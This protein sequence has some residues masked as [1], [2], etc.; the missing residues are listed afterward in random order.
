MSIQ[1]TLYGAITSQPDALEHFSCSQSSSVLSRGLLIKKMSF[2]LKSKLP[3]KF[4]VNSRSEKNGSNG[5]SP[6]RTRI[7]YQWTIWSSLL[8]FNKFAEKPLLLFSVLHTTEE[9]RFKFSTPIKVR[10]V[11]IFP[12]H[13]FIV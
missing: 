1:P 2:I 8:T 13:N 9:K 6:I 12:N 7:S 3:P 5:D 4:S 10:T 11:D